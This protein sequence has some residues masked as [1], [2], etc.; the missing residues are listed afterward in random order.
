MNLKIT[1][2]FFLFFVTTVFSQIVPNYY[3]T[4]ESNRPKGNKYLYYRLYSTSASA[5]PATATEFE[6]SF[7][8]AANFKLAGYVAL[9]TNAG[10]LN[11]SSSYSANLINFSNQT[12]LKNAIGNQT[13]Y[14]GFSGDGFTIVVSGYFI[15]KQTGTYTF[16]IEGD[17][18][19]DLFINDQN[20]ANHYGAH[21]PDP[22]GTHIGTISLVAGKKYSFRA[23][24]Q[25]GGGGEVM[26]LFWKKPSEAS[27]AVW[28]QDIEE[29]TGEEV[30]PSGLV[31]SV[32]PGNWYTYPKYGTAVTDLKGNATGTLGANMSYNSSNTGTFYSDG[33]GD[34]IDFGK[35]PANF[36]TGDIS[37]FVWVKATTL[38]SN[39]NIFITKWFSDVV[40]N[41]GGSDFHYDLFNNGSN[42]YQHL[43]TTNKSDMYGVTPLYSNTW[44]YVG[45]A[46][47]NG[48]LQMYLNGTNDGNVITGASRST[49]VNSNLWLG[50]AR[51]NGLVTFNGYLGSVHIYNRAITQDEVLQNY[52]ATKHKYGL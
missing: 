37:V 13:P 11:T 10:N 9:T 38:R 7:A 32:D 3:A 44:Y 40:G 22:I 50:D 12:D 18:A 21:G 15:P 45:F 14:S 27:G 8:T 35:T 43:F 29:L 25:E 48:N 6:T 46:I 42:V 16:T 36:P 19:V 1:Y 2:I 4:L 24:M 30:V 5:F 39:W 26:R 51:T 33:D 47:S 23:R 49:A 20:V 34:Y 17:D 31:F 52:N 41:S 28:Y